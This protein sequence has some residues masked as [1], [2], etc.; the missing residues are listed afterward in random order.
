MQSAEKI[1]VCDICGI[2][3]FDCELLCV[4]CGTILPLTEDSPSLNKEIRA[5]RLYCSS[6]HSSKEYFLELRL[7]KGD[8]IVRAT[9]GPM[10]RLKRSQEKIRTKSYL[11]A[12]GL[13]NKILAQK[14][15]GGYDDLPF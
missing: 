13:Y 3:S 10:G 14:I 7:D 5:E 1:L 4:T 6:E 15:R 11:E 12:L 8:H 9:W 2:E